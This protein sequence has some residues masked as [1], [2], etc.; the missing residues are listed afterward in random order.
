MGMTRGAITRLADRLIAKALVIRE[1]SAN[2]GRAQTLV[3]TPRGGELVPRLAALAD[4]NDAE[5]F[6]C[7]TAPERETL[8]QLLKSLAERGRMTAIPIA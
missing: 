4:S 5:F 6:G 3:L 1:A 7:L 8:E 2:D